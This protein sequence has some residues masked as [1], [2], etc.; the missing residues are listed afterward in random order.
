MTLDATQVRMGLTGNVFA[1]PVGTAMPT[2]T[3]TA[4]NVAFIDLGYLSEDAL[5]LTP[6]DTLVQVGAWQSQYDVRRA[7]TKRE[8]SVKFKLIQDNTENLKLAFGGGAV[9][10]AAGPPVIATY[11][12]PAGATQYERAF[13]LQV[14]DG[15][16]I[17][18]WTLYRGI[19]SLAGDLTIKKDEAVGYDLDIGILPDSAGLTWKRVTNDL[20]LVAG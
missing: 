19:P 5:T 2:D 15:S 17:N 1:G 13:V 6:N 4:L 7:V 16:I 11:T 3:A 9:T 10:V 18:R 8:M 20:A 14:V 12:P